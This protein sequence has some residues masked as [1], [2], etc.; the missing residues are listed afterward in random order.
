MA[1]PVPVDGTYHPTAAVTPR[2]PPN[3]HACH[4]CHG[5]PLTRNNSRDTRRDTPTQPVTPTPGGTP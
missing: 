5:K 4:A 3:C 1:S 2:H